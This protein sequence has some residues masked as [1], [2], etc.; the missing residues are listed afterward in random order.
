M[1]NGISYAVWFQTWR[2]TLVDAAMPQAA[3]PP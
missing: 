2:L 3:S 1:H